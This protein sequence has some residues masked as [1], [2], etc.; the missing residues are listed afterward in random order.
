M[1]VSNTDNFAAISAFLAAA[2]L[3]GTAE[4]IVY[5]LSLLAFNYNFGKSPHAAYGWK[6]KSA[7]SS[8]VSKNIRFL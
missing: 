6:T 5:I 1:P 3:F 8:S 2:F 7:N 4:K